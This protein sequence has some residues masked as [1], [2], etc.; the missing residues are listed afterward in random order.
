MKPGFAPINFLILHLKE[1][2]VIFFISLTIT[3]IKVSIFQF[4]LNRR[5]E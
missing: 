3:T 4:Q 1:E 2:S 5:Q